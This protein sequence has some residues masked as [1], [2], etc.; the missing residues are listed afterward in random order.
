MLLE[1]PQCP[2]KIYSAPHNIPGAFG[3]D[4]VIPRAYLRS[5]PVPLRCSL[6]WPWYPHRVRCPRPG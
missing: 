5:V 6:E 1:W 3:M 4:S 2:L